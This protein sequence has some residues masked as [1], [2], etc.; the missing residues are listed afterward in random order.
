MKLE[1]V[2]PGPPPPEPHEIVPT[3]LSDPRVQEHVANLRTIIRRAFPEV[4]F[5]VYEASEPAL[6]VWLDAYVA[7]NDAD[8]PRLVQ[9]YELEVLLREGLS[10]FAGTL[11]LRAL[12][13]EAA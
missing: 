7:D 4:Q 5:S 3:H 2:F 11:P 6:G 9:E 12:P 10:L 13:S 1:D 8:L